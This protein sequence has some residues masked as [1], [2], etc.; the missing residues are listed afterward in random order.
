MINSTALDN[1]IIREKDRLTQA[2][3]DYDNFGNHCYTTDSSLER[4]W[5]GQGWDVNE[6]WI[7]FNKS[8]AWRP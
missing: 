2:V 6:M 8:T 5:R 7:E 1:A 4:Y 3:C